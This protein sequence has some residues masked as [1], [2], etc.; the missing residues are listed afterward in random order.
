[1]VAQSLAGP[2]MEKDNKAIAAPGRR[3]GRIRL[4]INGIH[5]KSG[6]GITYIRELIP[7]LAAFPDLE[8]HLFLH[9]DQLAQ[10][11]PV[12]QNIRI[13]L[14]NFSQGTLATLLWEQLVA[15]VLTR[16]MGA[17]IVFSPAN[18]GPVC[19]RNH[20]ILLRN[21]VSVF[22][23]ESSFTGKIYWLGVGLATLVSVLTARRALAVSEFAKHELTFGLAGFLGHRVDVVPHGTSFN[24]AKHQPGRRRSQNLLAVS[25]IY[26]Q[27]NYHTLFQ[28]FA[29]LHQRYPELNL[30][31]A[32]QIIDRRYMRRISAMITELKL[33]HK[34]KFLGRVE[35]EEL[36]RLYGNCRVFVFPSLVETF[37]NPLLEA[38]AVGAPIA[39]SNSAAMPEII[40]D[41]GI[42]FDPRDAGDMAGKIAE[43]LDDENLCAEMSARAVRRAHSFSWETTAV[44]TRDAFLS[45]M[46]GDA[47]RQEH[48]P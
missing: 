41:S 3:S 25:D 43:L 44:K 45:M 24:M 13:H 19:V 36:N 30:L 38:M 29:I 8:V 9:R 16:S 40:G 12:D 42:L 46:K 6:G 22:L 27:K 33:E 26:I 35:N 21:A 23:V 4:V 34:I 48:T 14:F 10:F 2:R 20:V 32:G 28:A 5:S 1:M 15:P 11:Y 7:K 18:Y 31:I 47:G 17:D 37:G 39:C